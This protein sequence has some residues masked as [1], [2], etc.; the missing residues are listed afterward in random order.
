MCHFDDPSY[1]KQLYMKKSFIVRKL[2]II[3]CFLFLTN[4]SEAQSTD[5]SVTKTDLYDTIYLMD[6]VFFKAFNT[7]DTTKSK[8]LFTDDLEFY[9]DVGG[10]TNYDQ[11]LKSIRYRCNSTTKV[12]R[13]LVPGSLEVYPIKD[14][15]A[16]EIGLHRFYYT[17]V[18][19]EEKLDG[20]FRFV[21]IWVHKNNE[22]KISRAISFDH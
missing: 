7:C 20:T 9:H 16:I 17:E 22:W 4:F 14:Y 3:M 19:K 13:E 10:L 1:M 21:H 8:S 15:G 12:R 5:Q 2:G 18:D 11:N 6:S